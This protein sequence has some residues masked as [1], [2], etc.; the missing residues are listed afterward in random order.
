MLKYTVDIGMNK[1]TKYLFLIWFA[2]ISLTAECQ[3]IQVSGFIYQKGTEQT[4]PAVNIRN[5]RNHTG[6]ISN[7]NGFYTI[8][9]KPEDSVE[10]SAVG[11]VR[12]R[13]GLPEGLQGG[14][15]TYDIYLERD[16]VDLDNVVINQYSLEK[17]KE[18]F[19]KM[20]LKEDEKRVVGDPSVYKNYRQSPTT[21]GVH[22]NGP[23]S[24]IYNKLSK[25]SKELEKL[26]DIKSGENTDLSGSKNL[27]RSMVI[28]VT[29]LPDNEI[30]DFISWCNF[31]NSELAY[32]DEY[33]FKSMVKQKYTDYLKRNINDTIPADTLK[34]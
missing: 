10:V 19:K 22:L 14:S 23:F 6:T 24:W 31:S 7:N 17:F 13:Y 4:V 1:K 12:K 32:A 5:M 3:F 11:F 20:P 27:N 34:P 18:A 25:K 28:E 21:F 2:V 8:L 30:D 26:R 33:Y 9:L 16:I 15:Y 29:G